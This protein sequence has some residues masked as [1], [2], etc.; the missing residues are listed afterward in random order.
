MR[1]ATK[2][3]PRAPIVALFVPNHMS[4]FSKFHSSA[5]PLEWKSTRKPPRP[6]DARLLPIR[7][8][9]V[10]VVPANRCSTSWGV[11]VPMPTRLVLASS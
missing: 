4:E 2:D 7:T 6:A 1:S 8:P 3:T 11:A 5:P 9:T 10:D